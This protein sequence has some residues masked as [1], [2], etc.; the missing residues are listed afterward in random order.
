MPN[1][2]AWCAVLL[3]DASLKAALLAI[4]AAALLRSF[5]VRDSN[6]RHRVWT[7]VLAGMVVLPFLSQIVPALRF[8][9]L[10]DVPFLNQ[11]LWLAQRDDSLR[12]SVAAEEREANVLKKSTVEARSVMDVSTLG[13]PS[14][15]HG[16]A[17]ASIQPTMGTMGNA[18]AVPVPAD[19]K[20]ALNETPKPNRSP[21]RPSSGGRWS[22]A[23][24]GV[25]L[26]G[27]FCAAFWLLLGVVTLHLL[28]RRSTLVTP[29]ELA[30]LGL[31][32]ELAHRRGRPLRVLECPLIRVPLSAGL[33]RSA[34]LLPSDWLT[35]SPDKLRDVFAHERTHIERGDCIVIVLAE[36]NRCLYWFHPIAWWLRQRLA[37]LAEEVCDD[38]AIDAAGDRT[39]YA[40]HLLE[41]AGAL[42]V[43]RSRLVPTALSMARQSNVEGRIDAILDVARPLSKR[44]SRAA[45]LVLLLAIVVTVGSAAALRPS[46]ADQADSM[47]VLVANDSQMK[48]AAP[49]V[50]K[51]SSNESVR[52]QSPSKD[53]AIGTE[54]VSWPRKFSGHVTDSDGHPIGQAKILLIWGAFSEIGR[55]MD[56]CEVARSDARGDFAFE[57]TR[58]AWV[59]RKLDEPAQVLAQ[60]PDYGLDLLPL[61]TFDIQRVDSRKRERLQRDVDQTDGAGRIVRRTLKLRPEQSIHGRLVDLE[62]RPLPNVMVSA[63]SI[64]NL[65]I[66]KLL[67]AFE[68]SDKSLMYESLLYV[69]LS[70][71]SLQQLFPPVRTDAHGAFTFRGIG[72][73]QLVTLIF[74]AEGIEAARIYVVGRKMQPARLPQVEFY[75]NGY[76]DFYGGCEF[77]YALGPSAP[78]IGVVKDYDT[79][80]PI[81]NTVVFVERLFA[82]HGK[83][84]EQLRLSCRY[85]RSL[86]DKQGRFRIVG[87]P[88]GNTHVLRAAPPVQE[89]YLMAEKDISPK[90]DGSH[91]PIEIRVKQG[92]WYEGRVTD[93]TSGKP[94]KAHVDHLA[95]ASNPN[96]LDTFGLKQGW[97]MSRYSTDSNGHF[98]TLGLPGPG[99]LLIRATD[100]QNYPRE[101][102]ADKVSGYEAR[103]KYIPTTPVGYPLSNWNLISQVDPPKTATTFH[104]DF[105]LDAGQAIPGRVVAPD[106]KP[107]SDAKVLGEILNEDF[108]V[109]HTN[110][111]FALKSYDGKGPRQLLVQS[112]NGS[113]VGQYRLEGPAPK[114]IVVKLEPAVRVKGRL[115]ER[116]TNLPAERYGIYCEESTVGEAQIQVKTDYDGRFEIKGLLAG[117][118]YKMNA[119]NP[120]HFVNDKNK[121]QIDLKQAKPGALIDLG[122]IG[123]TTSNKL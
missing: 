115:I 108:W 75:R 2:S 70:L 43:Q 76:Q 97:E 53:A 16:M 39:V 93:K 48:A 47:A 114:E 95:L 10:R 92:I 27:F 20:K 71:D 5:R 111:E 117:V 26:I 96:K 98:R 118:G 54:K 42:S 55:P 107:H 6:L 104:R 3:V 32:S 105:V 52:G 37:T 21:S 86:T 36:I 19:P 78:V 106:G 112:S 122:D 9:F 94:V 60:A 25:W 30:D 116:E 46:R 113:L 50:M 11:D 82:E 84:R 40:R 91:G 77:T 12:I 1:L 119:A 100:L 35:W 51:G 61:E 24:F 14:P 87:I 59:E 34:I 58:Q 80:Q 83:Q 45:S 88:P 33:L 65:K 120:G 4:V 66:E 73:D 38:A 68:K 8:P 28:R 101:I 85:M 79:G 123:R 63:E 72:K 81:P 22:I 62:G 18:A 89:P 15:T 56:L 99:V 57:I 41:V 44:L 74:Q 103:S 109:S 110:A 69:P 29:G 17:G 13:S 49:G 64:W 23:V 67:K 102:G 121:F 31:P 90:L 7:G